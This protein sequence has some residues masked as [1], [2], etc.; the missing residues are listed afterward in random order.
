MIDTKLVLPSSRSNL[1]FLTINRSI[2]FDTYENDLIIKVYLWFQIIWSSELSPR[3]LRS[4]S[5]KAIFHPTLG[6]RRRKQ[7]LNS[8]KA[9]MPATTVCSTEARYPPPP[10]QSGPVQTVRTKIIQKRWMKVLHYRIYSW[11]SLYLSLRVAVEGPFSQSFFIT[12]QSEERQ[13]HQTQGHFYP[14]PRH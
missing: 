3:T 12:L 13:I 7:L 6:S 2:C 4:I 10:E 11:V 8:T 5:M 14:G 9:R 1:S